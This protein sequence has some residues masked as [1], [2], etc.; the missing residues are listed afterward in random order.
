MKNWI[1]ILQREQDYA[2]ARLRILGAAHSP[3]DTSPGSER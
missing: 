2:E 1:K 3:L